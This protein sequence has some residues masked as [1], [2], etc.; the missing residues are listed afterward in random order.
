MEQGS[1]GVF[2]IPLTRNLFRVLNNTHRNPWWYSCRLF[3]SPFLLGLIPASI[4]TS[5]VGGGLVTNR[6]ILRLQL[7][8]TTI[9]SLIRISIRVLQ[10]TYRQPRQHP[11][12]LFVPRSLAALSKF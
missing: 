5:S 9:M 8:D 2:T 4:K 12:C 11:C 1:S 10:S 7:D 6:R 3:P